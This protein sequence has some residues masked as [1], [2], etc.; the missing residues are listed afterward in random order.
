MSNLTKK[1]YERLMYLCALQN[2]N[3]LQGYIKKQ[4]KKEEQISEQ[5]WFN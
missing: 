4:L 1:Y 2:K 5:Q 3:L